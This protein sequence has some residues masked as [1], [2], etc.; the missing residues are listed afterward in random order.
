MSLISSFDPG[1]FF[2]G[3][4]IGICAVAAAVTFADWLSSIND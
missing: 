4:I 1:S 2:L 3:M